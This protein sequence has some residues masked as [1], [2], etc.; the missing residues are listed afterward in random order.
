MHVC[1]SSALLISLIFFIIFLQLN[2]INVQRL[3]DTEIVSQHLS[4]CIQNESSVLLIFSQISGPYSFVFYSEVRN[5]L[6][7]GRDPIGRH[8]LLYGFTE[9]PFGFVLSSVANNS[10]TNVKEVPAIG[11][12]EI[13]LTRKGTDCSKYASASL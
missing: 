8:S 4:E 6:W 1:L 12:F 13:D 3:S 9:D 11:L 10:L 2:E 7:F 5:T